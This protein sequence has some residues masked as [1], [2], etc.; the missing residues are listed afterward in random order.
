MANEGTAQDTQSWSSEN[1]EVKLTPGKEE[2][3]SY[4]SV[5]VEV[6]GMKKEFN[7]S[8]PKLEEPRVF[9]ADITG[10]GKEEAVIIFN[11]GRGTGLSIDEIH[12]LNSK[13]LSEIKVQSYQEIVADQIETKVTRKNN[14]TLAIKVKSQG[15]EYQFDYHVPDLNFKQ[16]K[17]SFGGVINYGL[18]NQKIISRLG[19]SV[20]VSPQYV[21]DFNVTYKFDPA[22]N[23]LI[24]DQITFVP[25]AD[26]K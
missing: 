26:N 1:K 20:G 15:K 14:E 13:D 6:N 23:E 7:W 17:L 21:G 4:A 3:S 2:N 18:E 25:S 12:V 22:K 24:A 10:D 9:Y 11:T 16:D 5:T 8:F 19:A